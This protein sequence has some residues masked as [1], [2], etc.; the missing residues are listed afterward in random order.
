MVF[1]MQISLLCRLV[2]GLETS[3]N[4]RTERLSAKRHVLSRPF[5][6]RAVAHLHTDVAPTKSMSGN[7]RPR[8]LPQACLRPPS[9][10]GSSSRCGFFS[11]V[12]GFILAKHPGTH[13]LPT[14]QHGQLLHPTAS[15]P[16]QLPESTHP[17]SHAQ[18]A[19]FAPACSCAPSPSFH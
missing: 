9:Q 18:S 10:C 16:A 19:S 11:C 5:Q 1:P 13:C 4:P 7:Q 8:P 3:S 12:H 17:A 15:R 6:T 2:T 14:L